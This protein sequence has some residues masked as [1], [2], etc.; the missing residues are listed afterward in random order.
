MHGLLLLD[1]PAGLSSFD[2][3]R[4]VRRHF[5]TRKVGHAG[6]LD[7]L[8]TGVLPVAIGEGTKLLQFLLAENK[9]YRATMRL[10]VTTDTLDSEGVEL[11]RHEVPESVMTDLPGVFAKFTGVIEQI[12]PMFSALKRNGVP[13]YKLARAGEVV[14]REA[15]RVSIERLDL[16]STQLPDVTIEVDCTKGTYIRT[17]CADIGEALGC[18]AHVVALRRLRTG[19]YPIE[20]CLPL[21]QL[22]EV[23]DVTQHP[24]FLS[25]GDA[26]FD[27]PAV[28]LSAVAM[29]RLRNGV[30]P[31]IDGVMNALTAK[32]GE[33]VRLFYDGILQAIA[34]FAPERQ[35]DKRGDFELIRIFNC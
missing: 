15:R 13:L 18:G 35:N 5:K 27:R 19:Q 6:T 17:L 3:V 28:E 32:D 34:R 16:I 33:L 30:P 14:E 4:Q 2:V 25:V 11:S 1:K 31:E 21:E 26:L 20:N 12:P 24:S 9:S 29:S 23:G 10:G 22:S 7:P 8:A